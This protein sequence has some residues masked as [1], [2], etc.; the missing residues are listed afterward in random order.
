ML[1][2]QPG[3]AVDFEVYSQDANEEI[4]HCQ[5]RVAWSS[6][7]AVPKLDMERLKNEMIQSK[8]E[9]ESVYATCARGLAYGPSLQ[10]ITNLY[11]GNNQVLAQLRLPGNVDDKTGSYVMHP[12]LMEVRCKPPPD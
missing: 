12:S 7:G 3:D 9:R 8:V 5:G 2:A 4:V 1:L 6:Q 11:L 10:A